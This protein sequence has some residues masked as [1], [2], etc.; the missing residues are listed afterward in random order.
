MTKPAVVG[1]LIKLLAISFAVAAFCAAG[2]HTFGCCVSGVAKVT[3]ATAEEAEGEEPVVNTT[4]PETLV[5]V[6]VREAPAPIPAAGPAVT[7]GVGELPE[8]CEA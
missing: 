2:T 3:V 4:A 5:L 1:G 8:N 7:V 6:V